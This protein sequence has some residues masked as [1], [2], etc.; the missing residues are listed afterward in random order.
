METLTFCIETTYFEM[1]SDEH[2]QERLALGS[3]LSLGLA[4]VDMESFEEIAV[5]ST[6]LKPSICLR[7]VD[8]SFILIKKTFKHYMN[9][10]WQSLQFSKKKEQ[11]N[12][13]SFLDVLIT[14]SEQEFR[15]T[16]TREYLNLNYHHP[17]NIKESFIAYNIAQ[18]S[19][20]VITIH[21]KKKGRI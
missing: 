14:C 15:S 19:L 3:P 1:G 17:Y 2:R 21:I 16:F 9:S 13:L 20:V 8:D 18:K 5:E 7:Y 11:D 10:I 4:N 12:K 6:L